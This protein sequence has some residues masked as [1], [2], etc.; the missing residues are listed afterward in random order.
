MP[1]VRF[2]LNA[3]ADIASSAEVAQL[4]SDVTD[5]KHLL[6]RDINTDRAIR[7]RP[8]G[9]VAVAN[10]AGVGITGSFV[11]DLGSPPAG[12]VWGLLEVV[13]TGKDEAEAPSGAVAS[14]WAGATP[15]QATASTITDLPTLA[16]LIRPALALPATFTFSGEAWWVKDQENLFVVVRSTTTA[17]TNLSAVATV[18]ELKSSAVSIDLLA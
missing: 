16:S 4:A 18:A 10:A 1:L 13:V 14:L 15:R 17:V 3:E 7:Q 6:T 2:A 5:V 8:I 12:R 9:S 11:I